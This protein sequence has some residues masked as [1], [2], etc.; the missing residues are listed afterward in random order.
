MT[1]VP[2]RI[3]IASA[4]QAMDSLSSC[5]KSARFEVLR[6]HDGMSALKLAR[7]RRIDLLITDWILP[8]MN[9]LQLT[10]ALRRDPAFGELPIIWLASLDTQASILHD[11][12]FDNMGL[13]VL[14]PRPFHEQDLLRLTHAL[15][16]EPSGVAAADRVLVIDDDRVNL[17][18]LERRLMDKGYVPSLVEFGKDGLERAKEERY[19]AVLLDLRLPDMDGFTVLAELRKLDADVPVIVMT[20]HGSEEV[21]VK[22]LT[23]GAVNYLIKPIDRKELLGVLSQSIEKARQLKESRSIQSQLLE[24]VQLLKSL[25]ETPPA[26]AIPPSDIDPLSPRELEIAALIAQGLDNKE[27]ADRLVLSEKTVVNHLTRIY[28]KLRVSNRTQALL[29]CL[30]H[31]LISPTTASRANRGGHSS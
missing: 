8:E 13:A 7:D 4:D 20:A 19:Q 29:V 25:P 5:L 1:H 11:R 28:E 22:A 3:L 24:A 12:G 14:L 21:A 30:K 15:L 16:V 31:Q 27:I 9:G 23:E 6:A 18:L 26:P 2:K 17:D 10:G